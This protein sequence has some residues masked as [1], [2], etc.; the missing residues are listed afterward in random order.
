M[1]D[2]N[3]A[4]LAAPQVG[5]AVAVAAVWIQDNPRYPYKPN[6]PLTVFVNQ[7]LPF[8]D[9]V[10][11]MIYEGCLSVPNLR[12]EVRCSMHIRID[13]LNRYGEEMSLNVNGLTAGTFQHEFDHLEGRLFV[14]RVEDIRSLCTWANFDVH[15]R[16]DF[17]RRATRIVDVYGS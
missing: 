10:T 17:V 11:E 2:V 4:G 13:A 9:D 3:G 8:L 7:K 16:A 6:F 14:D 12:G 15:H 1:K 5:R